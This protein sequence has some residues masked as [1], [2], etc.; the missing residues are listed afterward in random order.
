MSLLTVLM[1]LSIHCLVFPVL[2]NKNINFS[3]PFPFLMNHFKVELLDQLFPVPIGEVTSFEQVVA[4]LD[5]FPVVKF[6][7]TGKAFIHENDFTILLAHSAIDKQL[8]SHLFEGFG[9]IDDILKSKSVND[10]IKLI[11]VKRHFCDIS[12]NIIVTHGRKH[13]CHTNRSHVGTQ[14]NQREVGR[15]LVKLKISIRSSTSLQNLH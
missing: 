1:D 12:H 10:S 6:H 2:Q 9:G 3:W 4:P 11:I 14:V 5:F 8:P 15:G 7:N 13:F